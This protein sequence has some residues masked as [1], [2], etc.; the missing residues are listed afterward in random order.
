MLH[1]IFGVFFQG[2]SQYKIYWLNGRKVS[3]SAFQDCESHCSRLGSWFELEKKPLY[4]LDEDEGG[5]TPLD[6]AYRPRAF[7]IAS[8]SSVDSLRC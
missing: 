2:I 3:V 7:S 6:K 4:R 1:L 8:H 5:Y